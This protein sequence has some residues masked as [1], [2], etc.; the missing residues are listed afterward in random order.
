MDGWSANDY[1]MKTNIVILLP[2]ILML[3]T[4]CVPL[5]FIGMA[6]V[7]PVPSLS[8]KKIE[9][10]REITAQ[11]IQFVVLGR[12]TRSEII[13]RLGDDFRDSPRVSAI[14]Y[15]WQYNGL[16]VFWSYGFIL[17]GD[18]EQGEADFGWR[19][20]FVAFDQEGRVVQLQLCRLKRGHSLDEQLENWA[21]SHG[22]TSTLGNC[23]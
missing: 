11:E 9:Q 5:G 10:G 14:A 4:S 7:V 16:R 17:V 12:T 22:A 2:L 21:Q 3:L 20:L 18:G 23:K 1:S 8:K 19:A 13:T 15:S 6:T